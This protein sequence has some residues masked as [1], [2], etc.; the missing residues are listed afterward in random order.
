MSFVLAG[1]NMKND[2]KF[3]LAEQGKQSIMPVLVLGLIVYAAIGL[4]HDTLE[5]RSV[6]NKEEM[7][8]KPKAITF[9]KSVLLSVWTVG[10]NFLAGAL[11]A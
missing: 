7:S 4:F 8:M 6:K 10:A 9:T 11:L 3:R 1:C 2:S 5:I